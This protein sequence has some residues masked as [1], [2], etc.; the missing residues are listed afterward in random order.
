MHLGMGLVGAGFIGK[1]HARAIRGIEGAALAAV[2]SHHPDAAQSIAAEF[3]GAKVAGSFEELLGLEA[4][5]AV[6]LAVPNDLHAP[7][8]LRALAAGKHVFVE[9]PMATSTQQAE[10]MAAAAREAHRCLMVGHMWRFDPEAE[11]LRQ[12]VSAGRLGRIVKTKGYGIHVGWGPSGWFTS[13]V[14]AGGGAL[15]DMG[16]HAIDTVRFLTGD[17]R[18]VRVY[19]HLSTCFGN[20]DVDDLGVVMIHWDTGAVSV[21]ESGWWNPHRDGPEAAT[22]LFGTQGYGRLFPTELSWREDGGTRI[23]QASFPARREH[24]D[25]QLY[26]RQMREFASA[27]RE[28]REPSA[29]ADHGIEAV[30]ICEAAYA[31]AASGNAVTLGG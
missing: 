16:V 30:R 3:A 15:I 21:I 5:T 27:I 28:G 18:A 2:Y 13:R 22:Q 17:P 11:F 20:Y 4:V 25:P 10:L 24:C 6:I 9:K 19:A 26:E 7:Y 8:A 23:E 29:A 31:S 12:R 14:R 1:V